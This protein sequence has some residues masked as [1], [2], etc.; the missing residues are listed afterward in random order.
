MVDGISSSKPASLPMP[1]AVE[2]PRDA[3]A[4]RPAA[5][6]LP[7]A[8]LSSEASGLVRDMAARSPVDTARVAD[9]RAKID[10]GT[11]RVDP[12]RIADA[13]IAQERGPPKLR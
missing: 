10:S 3:K 2:G 11:Y 8:A 9:I 12:E 7:E 6:S 1:G 13:M 4:P 5:A